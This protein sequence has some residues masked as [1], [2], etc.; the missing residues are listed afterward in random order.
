[1]PRNKGLGRGLDAIYIDNALPEEETKDAPKTVPISEIDLC[2]DQPR[3]V[4]DPESLAA[5]ADSIR[6]NGLLQPVLVRRTNLGR[7]EIVAGERRFRA[8][9]LAGLSALPV[10]VIE[11]DDRAAAKYALIENLQ[12]EDLS[13]LEE[14]AAYRRLMDRW[15][16]TQEAVSAEV[17]KSRSAVANALRLLDLPE[18]AAALVADGSLTA[19]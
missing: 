11:A 16:L 4:F 18:E 12:R 15:G 6:E 10:S 13:P 8:A 2:A 9:K 5:L 17:G 19:G 14:A 3:K 1:M 7:Y